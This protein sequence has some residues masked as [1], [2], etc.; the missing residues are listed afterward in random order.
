[1]AE[2]ESNE[3]WAM[4]YNEEALS[5]NLHWTAGMT[6]QDFRTALEHFAQHAASKKAAGLRVNVTEFGF[7]MTPDLNEWRK[8]EILSQYAAAGVK[9]FAY[10]LPS[11]APLGEPQQYEGEPLVTGYF[12]SDDDATEWLE[13]GSQA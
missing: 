8:K 6:G 11:A 3:L 7:A 13:Q 10:V 9:R 5:I 1:M 12:H 2:L 4:E